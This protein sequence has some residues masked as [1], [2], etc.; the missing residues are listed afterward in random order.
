MKK[1][2]NFHQHLSFLVILNKKVILKVWFFCHETSNWTIYSTFKKRKPK[3]KLEIFQFC[4]KNEGII[5]HC[6]TIANL[7]ICRTNI[8]ANISTPPTVPFHVTTLIKKVTFL[9]WFLLTRFF[10]L[11]VWS[12]LGLFSKER[13]LHI[14]LALPIFY[15]H[16]MTW[17]FKRRGKRRTESFEIFQ[18]VNFLMFVFGYSL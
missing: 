13:P 7:E 3:K 8:R 11:Y 9:S 17:I 2:S 4:L 5:R 10:F 16:K 14:L 1:L 15:L 18:L 12:L 6:V